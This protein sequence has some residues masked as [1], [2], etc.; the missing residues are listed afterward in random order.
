MAITQRGTPSNQPLPVSG[1][2][3][4]GIPTERSK[5][6]KA[7]VEPAIGSPE[8]LQVIQAGMQRASWEATSTG[9]ARTR[10]I[11][12]SMKE[13][14]GV[15]ATSAQIYDDY[16]RRGLVSHQQGPAH[17]DVQLPG[18]ADPDAAPR[19]PK[20]EELSPQTQA[21]VHLALSKHGTSLDQM[22][23]DFGAQHDQAI[24]RAISHGHDTPY[25]QTFYSTGEPRQ[26][27]RKSAAEMGIPQLVHAQMNAFTSPNTKFAH[28]L[29]SGATVYPN[30]MAAKHAIL[31]AKMGRDPAELREDPQ[32]REMR[33]TGLVGL[34]DTRRVQGYPANMEKA[35]QAI[36]QYQ[37]GVAP[38]DWKT[39]QGAG[40]MGDLVRVNPRTHKEEPLGKSPWHLSPKT[41]PYANSWSDSHPQYFVSDIHSGG[42]GGVPHLSSFKGKDRKGVKSERESAIESVPF[43]HSAMDFAARQAMGARGLHSTRESQAAQWGE[44]Q[45]QRGEE[46]TLKGWST[47]HY[48]PMETAY[49]HSKITQ[50]PTPGQQSLF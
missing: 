13:T 6:A 4:Q 7:P 19:P 25:A 20:W 15:T 14:H 3:V 38:A 9:Q 35:A 16:R 48:P 43:F 17:T 26:V 11:E 1:E 5:F 8:R 12:Q 24:Q 50:R 31:H 45:L 46:A 21:H 27:I 28:T 47:S 39:G 10:N 23:S 41:G 44:E 33:S 32:A 37:A 30:D 29:K 42:G 18:M 40:P 36:H 49:P 2:R 34:G 22:T